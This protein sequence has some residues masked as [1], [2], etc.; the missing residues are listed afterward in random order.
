[1][2]DLIL[3]I[4]HHL[5]VFTLV[6]VVAAELVLLRPGVSGASLQ[7][8][9][10]IDGAYGGVAM[11]VL[12]AGTLRVFFG[13]SGADYYLQNPVFWMKIGALV[14]IGLLSIQPTITLIRWRREAKSAPGF[15]PSDAAVARS[16][17]FLAGE[18]LVLILIPIFAAAMARGFGP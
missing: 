4:A 17:K 13:A 3:A 5:A 11:L 18:V 7:R 8:L 6:S 12:A 1:M 15:V 16:R 10:K 2:L 14:L 9:G